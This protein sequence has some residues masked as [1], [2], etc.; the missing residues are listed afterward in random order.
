MLLDRLTVQDIDGEEGESEA[1]PSPKSK[2][3]RECNNLRNKVAIA[4]LKWCAKPVSL[5]T[6]PT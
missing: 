6:P 5:S 4:H 1:P 3:A 2:V